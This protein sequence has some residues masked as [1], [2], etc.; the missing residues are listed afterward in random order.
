MLSGEIDSFRLRQPKWG[1][2]VVNLGWVDL[3]DDNYVVDLG[4]IDLNEDNM[5]GNLGWV[6]LNEDN[7][8]SI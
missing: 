1:Q 6:D 8:L 4:W 5:S 3:N 2:Y 7:M